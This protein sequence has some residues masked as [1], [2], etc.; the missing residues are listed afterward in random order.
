[1][2]TKINIVHLLASNFFGG[3]EK[4]LLEHALS[5][6]PKRF[7]LNIASFREKNTSNQLV[8][9][10]NQK[11]IPAFELDGRHPF[12]PK[13]IS[14]LYKFLLKRQIEILCVHG[15]KANVIGRLAAWRA[16][17]PVI[18]ISRGWT[19]ES[20]KIRCYEWIDKFFLKFA[21]HVVAVSEGQRKKIVGLGV[22]LPGKTSVIHNAINLSRLPTPP[23]QSIRK[24][25]G[26]P[27]DSI[28]IASA[29][30]L[31]PEKNYASMIE[32]AHIV[33]AQERHAHFVVFGE[34]CLR[35]ELAE[36]VKL[37]GLTN[38]FQFPGFRKGLPSILRE[39]DIFM[40]PS[41]TEGL[42]NVALEAFAAKKPIVATAVGGTPEVVTHGESGY[43][44][45]PRQIELMAQYI[46]QLIRDSQL[47]NTMGLSGYAHVKNNFTFAKQTKEYE[48]LYA[49]IY[50]NSHAR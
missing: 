16:K 33:T 47:R 39:I 9:K 7:A 3:P 27:D 17:I 44:T 48:E 4:Q 24:E 38:Q 1:M 20:R 28:V 14:E 19:G 37:L 50:Q 11:K 6:D 29:G 49:T 23:L 45:E 35:H 8:E 34:G 21:E 41:F 10:A 42:P 18:V 36:K 2:T 13:V 26:L 25:L 5:L 40:L 32:V 31:S 15:Y 22:G 12:D 43:L 46:L 30:R